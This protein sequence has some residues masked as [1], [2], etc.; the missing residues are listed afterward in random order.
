M[1]QRVKELDPLNNGLAE[2]IIILST[3]KNNKVVEVNLALAEAEDRQKIIEEQKRMEEQR[4]FLEE[5]QKA[6]IIKRHKIRTRA[7]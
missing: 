4:M 6:K 3:D 7:S 1:K 5:Q 2:Q